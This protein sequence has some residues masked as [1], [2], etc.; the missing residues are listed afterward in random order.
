MKRWKNAP[1]F[2]KKKKKEK[3][4]SVRLTEKSKK[5]RRKSVAKNLPFVR[6]RLKKKRKKRK[7][8]SF[9]C[10]STATENIAIAF[11]TGRKKIPSSRDVQES[12][13][14]GRVWRFYL[15]LSIVRQRTKAGKEAQKARARAPI[16]PGP[17]T[18]FETGREA[19]NT[20][21]ISCLLNLWSDV[22][23][24]GQICPVRRIGATLELS[25][26]PCFLASRA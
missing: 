23:F 6:V 13:T 12:F 19:V 8:H 9:E 3:K 21:W 16:V 11:S 7:N 2:Q 4:Y 5:R 10:C 26:S 25:Q 20:L 24:R 18:R 1:S 22:I 15:A 17:R 14:D